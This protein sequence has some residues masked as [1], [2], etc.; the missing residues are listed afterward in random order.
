MQISSFQA[1]CHQFPLSVKSDGFTGKKRLRTKYFQ[2]GVSIHLTPLKIRICIWRMN[3][4]RVFFLGG[5]Y[6]NHAET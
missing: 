6:R 4:R 1:G 3:K 2:S 5:G